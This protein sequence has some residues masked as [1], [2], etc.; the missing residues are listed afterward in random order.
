MLTIRLALEGVAQE[1]EHG[2]AGT[3]LVLLRSP[4]AFGDF[5]ARVSLTCE[6]K[7]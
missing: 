4:L 3:F 1:V 5:K 2:L 6:V 7:S